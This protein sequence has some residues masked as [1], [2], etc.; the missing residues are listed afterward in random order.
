MANNV[1]AYPIDPET[2]TGLFRLELGDTVG[3]PIEP[4]TDPVTAEYQYI[5]DAGIN[6]LM[7]KY[8]DDPEVAM[9]KAMVSMANQMI[10]AAQDIQVDDIRIKTVEKA[11]LM[12]QMARDMI[13]GATLAG[14]SGF[15]VVPL[16]SA[17][18]ARPQGTPHFG[19]M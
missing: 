2:P 16:N 5:S 3:V 4:P 12:L 9:G 7:A 1:G 14:S 6:A 13:A 19:M 8:P 15:N 17:R 10:A 18:Y 11:N